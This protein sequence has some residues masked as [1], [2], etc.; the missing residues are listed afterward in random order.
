MIKTNPVGRHKATDGVML[1]GIG[2][3]RYLQEVILMLNHDFKVLRFT[4]CAY[5]PCYF[6]CGLTAYP[7]AEEPISF[8]DCRACSLKHFWS[9]RY[10]SDFLGVPDILRQSR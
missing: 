10:A 8:V 5:L 7:F 2:L 4:S 3:Q 1:F 6:A 9:S